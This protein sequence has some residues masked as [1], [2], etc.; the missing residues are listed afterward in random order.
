M[1]KRC[2]CHRKRE[3][4]VKAGMDWHEA[5]RLYSKPGYHEHRCECS[6]GCKHDTLGY[7]LCPSCSFDKDCM[8][9]R[10]QTGV[11]ILGLPIY[12]EKQA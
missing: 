2:D 1:A 7:A 11:G 4:A 12:P 6:C 9:A 3:A 8:K 10:G 5:H